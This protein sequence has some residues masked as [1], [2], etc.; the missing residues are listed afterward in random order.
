MAHYPGGR[1]LRIPATELHIYAAG[2][3]Y[4]FKYPPPIVCVCVYV[5]LHAL[6]G[7]RVSAIKTRNYEIRVYV[8]G[9]DKRDC[10]SIFIA[11][12]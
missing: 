12:G 10:L 4:A 9:H 7:Q 8:T 1:M 2:Q 11:R 3:P 6:S 5:C